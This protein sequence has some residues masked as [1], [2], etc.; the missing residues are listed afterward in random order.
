MTGSPGPR[1]RPA[2]FHGNFDEFRDAL[3]EASDVLYLADNAGEIVADQV[4]IRELGP[5]RVTVAVRGGPVLN[6]AT[7]HDARQTGLTSIVPVIDNG[8]DAPG[9]LLPDCSPAFRARFASADLVIAK[10]QGNFESLCDADRTVFAL[11][12]VKC[13]VVAEHT[14]LPVGTHVLAATGAR[15]G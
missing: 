13:G 10:G 4:L 5:A 6:D 11:F 2:P 3:D 14:G 12:K 7:M 9:T 15:H 8:S 1:R